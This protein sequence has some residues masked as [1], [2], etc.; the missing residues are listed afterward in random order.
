MEARWLQEHLETSLDGLVFLDSDDLRDLT[1]L[2]Q[3][4]R[5]SSVLVLIQSKGVLTRALP[6]DRTQDLH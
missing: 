6:A 5:D 1:Q 3:H 4:V 2:T